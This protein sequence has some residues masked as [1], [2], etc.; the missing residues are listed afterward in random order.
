[1]RGGATERERR[2]GQSVNA[3]HATWTRRHSSH[4]FSPTRSSA[5]IFII[6]LG[7]ILCYPRFYFFSRNGRRSF[8]SPTVCRLFFPSRTDRPCSARVQC[9]DRKR[10]S[11]W[12]YK[13][14]YKCAGETSKKWPAQWSPGFGPDTVRNR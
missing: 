3:V 1:M 2:R 10:T 13:Y 9:R 7:I 4:W 6:Y 14:R 11:M 12:L 5:S 8:L